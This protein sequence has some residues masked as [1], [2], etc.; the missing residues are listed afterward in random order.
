MA[1]SQAPL[2]PNDVRAMHEN[3]TPKQLKFLEEHADLYEVSYL[4][5]ETTHTLSCE[6]NVVRG[7]PTV[8]FTRVGC[9]SYNLMPLRAK[10]SVYDKTCA[11]IHT[12]IHSGNPLALMRRDLMRRSSSALVAQHRHFNKNFPE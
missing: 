1:D 12:A 10:P 9:L 6:G 3:A 4:N 2:T 8:T 11:D 5:V 7:A